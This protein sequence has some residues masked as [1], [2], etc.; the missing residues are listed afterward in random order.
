MDKFLSSKFAQKSPNV[1]ELGK[2]GK[3]STVGGTH[4]GSTMAVSIAHNGSIKPSISFMNLSR[5]ETKFTDFV[6]LE[7]GPNPLQKRDGVKNLKD[8]QMG[9]QTIYDIE[10]KEHL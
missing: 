3:R 9:S 7:S 8:I 5:E 1:V 4:L 6:D 10:R 2:D